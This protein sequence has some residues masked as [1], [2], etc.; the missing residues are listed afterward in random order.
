MSW[1]WY[2]YIVECKD[3]SY[4][5]GLTYQPD[6]RWNQHSSGFGSNYT[7]KHGV[8]AIVYC[9]EYENLDEAR[10]REKQIK[11]WSRIKKEKLIKG[12]WTKWQ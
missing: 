10:R 9:E 7:Q 5:T 6:K 3:N 8:K 4:Y 1:K 2:I 11:S 12:E